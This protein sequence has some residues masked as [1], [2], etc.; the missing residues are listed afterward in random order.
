MDQIKK[1]K[2]ELEKD[3]ILIAKTVA[4]NEKMETDLDTLNHRQE[5]FNN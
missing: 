2:E 3:T 4:D 5:D 1:L